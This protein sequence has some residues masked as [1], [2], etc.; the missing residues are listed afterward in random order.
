MPGGAGRRQLNG[1]SLAGGLLVPP[2]GEE[3]EE[4]EDGRR[5]CAAPLGG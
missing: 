5:G 4:E 2:Q 1:V 3:E